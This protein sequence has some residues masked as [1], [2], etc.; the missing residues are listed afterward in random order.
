[1]QT[2]FQTDTGK[3]RGH[4][5]DSVG[6][7]SN[8]AGIVLAV[9]ADGMGGHLAGE[10]ASMMAINF[11]EAEW[12]NTSK[13]DTPIEAEAWLK[14]IVGQLNTNLL[15]HSE[16]NEECNGMGTTLEAIIC[17]P[18]FFTLAHVG[19]SRSYL[20]NDEGFKQITEDHTFV[21]ELVKF[22]QISREDAEIHPRKNVITRALGTEETVDVD[23]KT[24]TWEE[25]DLILLCSDGLSNK[26]TNEQLNEKL[27]ENLPI[28]MIGNQL[29][30]Q[31]NDLGGEDNITLA[32]IKYESRNNEKG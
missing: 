15:V 7:F 23:I 14:N 16:Q 4:N 30:S 28:E 31:A 12:K 10:V 29:I 18:L 5:E 9:V 1:M 8:D 17:T 13:F 22:G 25:D 19:D 3:V 6:I 24:L 27:N 26:I 20:L 32:I 11:L 21:A 2:F